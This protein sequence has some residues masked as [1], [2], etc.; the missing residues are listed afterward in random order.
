MPDRQ[1]AMLDAPSN[2]G[3]RP[4]EPGSVPG[5]YKLPWA[6]RDRKLVAAIGATDAGT[7]VPPRY[8]AEWHPGDGDRN[9]AAIATFS[10]LRQ[11]AS[12]RCLSLLHWRWCWAAI[13][14]F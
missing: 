9:A 7:L 8:R 4:P 11:S 6:L 13:A 10:A 5:C 2:L 12:T 3:L 14:A 1:I